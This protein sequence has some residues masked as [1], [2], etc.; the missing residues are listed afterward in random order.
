VNRLTWLLIFMVQPASGCATAE[1]KPTGPRLVAYKPGVRIDWTTRQIEVDA[2]VVLREGPLELLACSPETKEHESLLRVDARGSH[3]YEAMGLIGLTPGHP[4]LWDEQNERLIPATGDVLDV[5]IRFERDN[6][7]QT[8]AAHDWLWDAERKKPM[9]PTR[10]LFTGSQRLEDGRLFVD[11]DGTVVTVV[12]FTSA[13]ISLPDSHSSDNAA[14]W[15]EPHPQRVPEKGTRCVLLIRAAP[16]S[17]SS[18]PAT[19]QPSSQP[20][21]TTS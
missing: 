1:S 9:K 5:R 4:V 8:V 3:I 21:K 11:L 15:L 2:E 10:W 20:S 17:S 19:S 13:L 16:S 14:L 12:N 18:Q 6:M 7:S